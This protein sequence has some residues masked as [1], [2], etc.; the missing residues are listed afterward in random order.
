MATP[1]REQQSAINHNGGVLLQAG[2]GSGKTFVLKEHL[3]HLSRLLIEQANKAGLDNNEFSILVRQKFRKVVLMTFTKKAAGELNIRLFQEFENL[4]NQSVEDREKWEILF[5]Q[6]SYLNVSTIHGFCYKLIGTGMFPGVS[7]DQNI[8]SAVEHKNMIIV[9]GEKYLQSHL[10]DIHPSLQ[11]LILKE[12]SNIFDSLY[13]IFC[14]PTLRHAWSE[15]EVGGL[16]SNLENLFESLFEELNIISLFHAPIELENYKD[17]AGKKWFDF[18]VHIDALIKSFDFSLSSTCELVRYFSELGFKLPMRPKVGKFEPELIE[19]YEKIIALRDFLKDHCDDILAFDKERMEGELI[20]PWLGFILNMF[21]DVDFKYSL[22]PGLTFSDMEYIVFKNLEKVDIC[23]LFAKEFDYFIVDEFQDTS[24]IQFSILEHLIQKDFTKL[25]C[26]GD[27]KQAIYGFRGGELAVFKNCSKRVETNLSLKNN[28]RSALDIIEFNNKFFEYVFKLGV[29]YQGDDPHTVVVEYQQAPDGLSET[30]LVEKIV[31]DAPE[32]EAKYSN[33][34]I[35][36]LEALALVEKIEELSLKKESCA[37][38]YKKLKPSLILVHL[39]IER[40]ISFSAQ[41]KIPLLED[42]ILGLFLILIEKDINT[43]ESRDEYQIFLLSSYLKLLGS[44]V[45][46]ESLSREVTSFENEAGSFGLYPAFRNFIYRLGLRLSHFSNNLTFIQTIIESV[47][48]QRSTLY[49][50]IT[51]QKKNSHS[52]G[53]EFGENPELVTIMSAHGSKGLQFPHVLMGGIYTNDRSGAFKDLIGKAPYSFKWVSSIFGKK[54]FKTPHYLLEGVLTKNK[55]FSENKRLFYVACT[56]AEKGLYW[57][58]VNWGENKK[59]ASAKS[60]W[61]AGFSLW[62]GVDSSLKV[63]EKLIDVSHSFNEQVLI[64]LDNPPPLFHQ[65]SLGSIVTSTSQP[66]SFISEL[67]VTKLAAIVVCPRKFYF[68]SICKISDDELNLIAENSNTASTAVVNNSD[69]LSSQNILR[70]SASRGTD[71][72]EY[73]SQVV[74][75][76]FS[77]EDTNYKNLRWLVEKLNL[78]R[79]NYELISEK[80]IKFELFGHMVSGIPDLLVRPFSTSDIFEV[81]DYKTGRYSDDKL[82][83]YYFQLMVYAYSQY[84]LG[85]ISAEKPCRLV[86]LFVDEEKIVDYK[87]SL[88]DV[89]KYLSIELGKINQA[90]EK[91]LEACEYCQFSIICEK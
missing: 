18:S 62:D 78:L 28:Y 23:D 71:I 7:G 83:A 86:V 49:K 8:L 89:E 75:S 70:S 5:S 44:D 76:D 25:F 26:V 17:L 73:L 77:V 52:L 14:D 19:H 32:R 41:V 2:A 56:R 20:T 88:L 30:G 6:L 10:R 57:C 64:Q 40:N 63:R 60:S 15:L 54:R 59:V 84:K 43:S 67:S 11:D 55:E 68:E 72:H 74:L 85:V 79:D 42:P 45:S 4:A 47:G 61:H 69:E 1:N 22:I 91:N 65:N 34:E 9:L 46:I 80:P 90:N 16:F 35:N 36:Y 33:L 39:L 87:V 53:L 37:V 13:A 38:L 66:I 31:V 27:L 24:H 3:I 29:G 12:K 82:P 48:T 58:E 50:V 21:R 51:E 81:W